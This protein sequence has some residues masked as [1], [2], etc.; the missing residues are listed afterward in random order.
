MRMRENE[1]VRCIAKRRWPC[2]LCSYFARA[3]AGA[4]AGIED[5]TSLSVTALVTVAIALPHSIVC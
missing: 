4:G 2:D 1:V 5:V 3:G